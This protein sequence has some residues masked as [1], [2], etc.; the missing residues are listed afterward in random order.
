MTDKGYTI[1]RDISKGKWNALT[2]DLRTG[3]QRC[4]KRLSVLGAKFAEERAHVLRVTRMHEQWKLA[5]T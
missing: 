5:F 2:G 4:I 1:F 3:K